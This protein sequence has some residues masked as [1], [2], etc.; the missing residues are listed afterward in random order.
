MKGEE[1]RHKVT[2]IFHYFPL[3]NTIFDY[4]QA[5]GNMSVIGQ[6]PGGSR[7]GTIANGWSQWGRSSITVVAMPSSPSSSSYGSLDSYSSSNSWSSSKSPVPQSPDLRSERASGPKT[8]SPSRRIRKTFTIKSKDLQQR[9]QQP[10]R[11]SWS[12]SQQSQ[13]SKDDLP[14]EI[15]TNASLSPQ[16]SPGR[17]KRLL[18]SSRQ[19]F[20]SCPELGTIDEE[21][22]SEEQ[23][24]QERR[25]RRERNAKFVD[26]YNDP[27]EDDDDLDCV[28]CWSFHK[29][30]FQTLLK[31]FGN[32]SKV[33][34]VIEVPSENKSRS[35]NTISVSKLKRGVYRRQTTV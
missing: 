26:P 6:V 13:E 15:T 23:L 28:D 1:K 9:Q 5:I 29:S 35:S 17:R 20:S 31:S 34:D 3:E 12:S 7:I 27:Y 25:E 19:S 11:R 18:L 10:R 14:E 22:T 16:P 30:G 33:Q 32:P 24:E 8:P 4:R 2:A 21:K